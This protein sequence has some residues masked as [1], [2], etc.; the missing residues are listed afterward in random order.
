M[1]REKEFMTNE[2]QSPQISK[3][4]IDVNNAFCDNAPDISPIGGPCFSCDDDE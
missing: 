1:N 4:D 3:I 2:Y